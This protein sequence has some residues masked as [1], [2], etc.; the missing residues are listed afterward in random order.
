MIGHG[1]RK[2]YTLDGGQ[3]GETVFRGEVI[4]PLQ[5][6]WERPQSDAI[7]FVSAWPGAE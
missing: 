6:P 7:C 1:C 4:N 3:T 2:A 5:K